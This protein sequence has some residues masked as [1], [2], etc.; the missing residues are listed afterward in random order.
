MANLSGAFAPKSDQLNFMDF[1][2]REIVITIERVEYRAND[3]SQRVWIY[4][5]GC[6]NKPYKPSVGMGRLLLDAWGDDDSLW[7][8]RSLKL[9][10]DSTVTFGKGEVG[11]IRIRAMSHISPDGF[12]GFIQKNRTIRVKQTIPLLVVEPVYYDNDRFE[13]ELPAMV[14]AV[15]NG[16]MT[17]E[18]INAQCGLSPEQL[19]RLKND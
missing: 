19:S 11:G 4:Y 6:N 10:G 15:K 8:G 12:T 3:Q 5:D 1:G 2:N 9:Y 18:D 13:V 16:S 7:V 17:I 14:D